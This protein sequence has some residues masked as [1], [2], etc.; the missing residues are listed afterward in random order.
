MKPMT[1]EQLSL[2]FNAVNS[3]ILV[4]LFGYLKFGIEKRLKKYEYAIGDAGDLNRKMHDRMVEFEDLVMNLKPID[5]ELTKRL[6]MTS[7]R[8][9]KYHP[10][11]SKEVKELIKIWNETFEP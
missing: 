1:I 9:D 2:I 3:T 5:K 10:N 6:L 7:S 8:L 11:V 4:L